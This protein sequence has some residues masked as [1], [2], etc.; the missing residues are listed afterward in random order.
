MVQACE[1]NLNWWPFYFNLL[2]EIP[3]YFFYHLWTNTHLLL[4]KFNWLR[5]WS[6]SHIVRPHSLTTEICWPC[7]FVSF[8]AML[9][10]SI[11]CEIRASGNEIR[12]GNRSLEIRCTYFIKKYVSW[13]GYR[14]LSKKVQSGTR[15]TFTEKLRL[16]WFLPLN[17]GLH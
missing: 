14:W 3:A 15:I 8:S 16:I 10:F 11:T 2:W 4:K 12:G 1:K 17:Q 9:I 13:Y 5:W 6:V 7:S